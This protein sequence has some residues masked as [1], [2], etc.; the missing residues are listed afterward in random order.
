MIQTFMEIIFLPVPKSP[1][2][3]R[4]RNFLF[5][6]KFYFHINKNKSFS[7]EFVPRDKIG[8]FCSLLQ[9]TIEYQLPSGLLM[10]DLIDPGFMSL[11]TDDREVS[12]APP[13]HIDIL[14]IFNLYII[15][16]D[17]MM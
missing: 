3:I 13:I 10:I 2:K 8:S 4:E 15:E 9:K 7:E 5:S 12:M 16:G 14:I 17:F 11:D 1:V 6:K